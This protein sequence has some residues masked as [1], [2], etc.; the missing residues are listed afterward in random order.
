MKVTYRFRLSHQYMLQPNIWRFYYHGFSYLD[1]VFWF[2]NFRFKYRNI[3]WQFNKY[4]FLF[5]IKYYS[6]VYLFDFSLFMI[7]LSIKFF[8]V[9]LYIFILLCFFNGIASL[10]NYFTNTDY[11]W[12]LFREQQFTNLEV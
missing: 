6:L 3:A 11:L 1:S 7:L 4:P 5:L 8:I 2:N 12:R 10:N 9:I